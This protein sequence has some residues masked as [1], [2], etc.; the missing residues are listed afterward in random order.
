MFSLFCAGTGE[1]QPYIGV[2]LSYLKY[3]KTIAEFIQIEMEQSRGFTESNLDHVKIVC[4]VI[5]GVRRNSLT[6]SADLI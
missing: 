6:G 4:H 1:K 2:F 3:S 5:R